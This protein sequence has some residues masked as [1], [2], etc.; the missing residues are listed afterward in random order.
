[1]GNDAQK[2][3]AL[4]RVLRQRV[5]NQQEYGGATRY[6]APR[7]NVITCPNCG[8]PRADNAAL[9]QCAYCGHQFLKVEPA[10]GLYLGKPGR[11]E[12]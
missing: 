6:E 8:S 2:H 7:T 3:L 12:K 5:A 10:A 11:Q 4:L 1:M 9:M